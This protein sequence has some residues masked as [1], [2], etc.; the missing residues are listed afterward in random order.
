MNLKQITV[1]KFYPYPLP[2]F[3]TI[4]NPSNKT[5]SFLTKLLKDTYFQNKV[6]E[7]RQT[8]S[9][10]FGGYSA[11][12]LK[13]YKQ[14]NITFKDTFKNGTYDLEPLWEEIKQDIFDIVNHYNIDQGYNFNFFLLITHNTFIE[15]MPRDYMLVEYHT[16]METIKAVID[17]YKNPIA[18]IFIRSNI[19]K[20]QF[21][22]WIDENWEDDD[23]GGIGGRLRAMM[24]KIPNEKGTYS[25]AEVDEEIYE[26][27]I[28]GNTYK[29]ISEILYDKHPDIEQTSDISWL[30]LRF[31]RY[32]RKE[33]K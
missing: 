30:K 31:S 32:K 28:K 18:A 21:K 15:I 23:L 19:T 10:P 27:R 4:V 26:L 2:P 11:Q 14:H 5:K 12:L 33:L 8:Y 25:N 29:T 6:I 24:P 7:L 1:F 16:G 22:E 3:Q 17:Y 13:D 9:I 20:Q